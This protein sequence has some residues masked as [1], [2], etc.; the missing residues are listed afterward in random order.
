MYKQKQFF[1]LLFSCVGMA[2]AWGV[3]NRLIHHHNLN[4]WLLMGALC[5]SGFI[6][7]F[8]LSLRMC[9]ALAV[10][11]PLFVTVG[12]SAF[13]KPGSEQGLEVIFFAVLLVF[14][15]PCVA[16]GTLAKFVTRYVSRRI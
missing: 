1:I 9:L 6:L 2:L 3:L 13:S 4:I 5:V 7:P 16:A 15:I 12:T 8:F 10:S 11:M 14:F